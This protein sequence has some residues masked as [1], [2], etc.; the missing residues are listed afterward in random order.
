MNKTLRILSAFVLC[1]F[2]ASAQ[3]DIALTHFIY[4]KFAINPGATG[5]EEGLCGNLI[6]RNQ[7]D[8]VNGAPN[9]VVFNAEVNMESFGKW[10]GGFGLNFTHDAIG[11][12][13]QNNVMLN[14]SHHI[15]LG[16]GRLGLGLGVGMVNF[17]MSPTWIGPQ[18]QIDPTFPGAS[19]AITFDLNFGL[20]YRA[21]NWYAGLSSTHLQASALNLTTQLPSTSGTG[22][23][24]YDLARHYYAMGGYT[25]KA[26]GPG[27]LDIQGTLQTDL[28]KYSGNLNAR[29]IFKGFLYGGLGFRNSDAVSVLLGWR[30]FNITT[31]K[32]RMF[33]WVGYSYDI[34]IGRL[35]KISN[36]THEIALK[37][38]YIPVIPITKAHHPKWL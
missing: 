17:G 11:F 31:P 7:W 6:Y 32:N 8:K 15:Q 4:N 21:E 22:T 25:F 18:T 9:S 16:N 28:R 2:G 14:Y 12:Q 33:M 13:R 24:P 38:C 3:Q 20:Y 26:L 30:A 27:D 29:Y 1:S 36:G 5:I 37:F 10:T 35:S 19:S 34:T 23:V